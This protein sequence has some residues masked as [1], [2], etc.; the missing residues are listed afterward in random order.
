MDTLVTRPESI[1]QTVLPEVRTELRWQESALWPVRRP[2]PIEVPCPVCG[3]Y[4]RCDFFGRQRCPRGHTFGQRAFWSGRATSCAL[5]LEDVRAGRM[6]I[7]PEAS[8][9]WRDD[10]RRVIAPAPQ[11]HGYA[12][13]A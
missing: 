9:R 6:V 10:G 8:L 2:Y 3:A 13:G 5:L 12:A 7:Y 4:A 1:S 11:G